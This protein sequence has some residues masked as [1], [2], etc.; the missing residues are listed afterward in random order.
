V[1]PRLIRRASTGLLAVA[2]V[3]AATLSGSGG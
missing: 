1:T 2:L 3:S